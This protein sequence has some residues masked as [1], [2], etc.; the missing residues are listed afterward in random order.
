MLVLI[1]LRTSSYHL[2]VLTIQLI[3]SSQNPLQETKILQDIIINSI[4]TNLKFQTQAKISSFKN[5]HIKI[6]LLLLLLLLL[7]L[8]LPSRGQ[9]PLSYYIYS[10]MNLDTISLP[11]LALPWWAR[12]K[13]KGGNF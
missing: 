5:P 1:H 6:D 3:Y 4:V 8:L 13:N 10:I 2:A 9:N 7:S 12:P 11:C